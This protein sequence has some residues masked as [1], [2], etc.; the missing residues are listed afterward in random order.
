MRKDRKGDT[1]LDIV[2]SILCEE[3]ICD[4]CLGRQFAKC[5]TNLTN[6][7]RG[8]AIRIVKAM[9][10]NTP[11]N[12][13]E[14][15]AASGTCWVCGG[16][17]SNLDSWVERCLEQLKDYEFTN[18]LVGSKLTGRLA[19]NEEI[20]WAES[21][22][23]TAEPLKSALNRELGKRIELLTG[24]QAEFSRPDI[25]LIVDL[26]R[27]RVEIHANPLFLYGR[28]LKFV[29]GLPQTKW[30]CRECGGRGCARCNLTGKMYPES[31]QELMEPLVLA[32]SRGGG[33]IFHGAGREDIDARMLGNGRPFVLEV[34]SPHKR[35]IDLQELE[36][37][38]NSS[39]KK[40]AV[41]QLTL[42]DRET[43]VKVKKSLLDKVYRLKVIYDHPIRE[44]EIKKALKRLEGDVEQT[45]PQRVVHRRADLTRRKRVYSA[46]LR[47]NEILIRCEGGLY[48]KEL[49]SGD[50][51]RTNPSLSSLLGVNVKVEELDVLE[52]GGGL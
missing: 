45:T 20:L 18:F 26:A 21:K 9:L 43:V 8:Q 38:M 11:V 27:D 37:A 6:K 42:V 5:S 22:T 3:P 17:F 39:Q 41:T 23:T 34:K 40:I 32:A 14:W 16:L 33:I 46:E 29:R 12:V 15:E 19:E 35:K 30:P 51:D 2:T 28:Y 25:L 24:K 52:V 48:V 50:N 47:G 44:E 31:V 7:Q 4:D 13:L 1:M 49:I 36:Q 10:E